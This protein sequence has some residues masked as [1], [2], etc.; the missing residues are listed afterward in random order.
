[1]SPLQ[2]TGPIKFSEIQDEFGPTVGSQHPLGSYRVSQLI[3]DRNWPLATGVPS[4]GPIKFSDFYGKRLNVVI[5]SGT[6]S[7]EFNV[8]LTNYWTT[9]T[10]VVVGGFKPVQATLAAQ[11]SRPNY[12][13]LLRRD[14]GGATTV[15]TSVKTGNW[16]TDSAL[17][18]Y[19]TSTGRVFGLGGSGGVGGSGNG[20]PGRPGGTGRNAIGFSYSGDLRIESGGGVFAGAGGGGGGGGNHHN[21]DPGG[22]DPTY[23]GGTGG[24]GRS[25]PNTPAPAGTT[26][27]GGNG[28]QG[29]RF[30]AINA[31]AG[32]GGG[33]GGWDATSI[34]SGGPAP[35]GGS[36]GTITGRG[37][38]GGRGPGGAPGGLGGG[39]GNAILR[40]TTV[41]VNVTNSGSCFPNTTPVVNDT[42][43]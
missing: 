8:T 40:R 23:T 19:V 28:A 16:P 30:P 2:T 43:T 39:P 25:S 6:G 36:N 15:N 12:R 31:Y 24:G 14:Y 32:S 1:M 7:A 42:F 10:P 37:G 17:T 11:G 41:T 33:G 21:P 3:G 26:V 34:G 22:F 18:V 35:G 27:K 9:K 4:T 13:V 20:S 29:G 38:A 5:D